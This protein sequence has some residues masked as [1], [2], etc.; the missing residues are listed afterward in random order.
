MPDYR[1]YEINKI[2]RVVGRPHH[3]TCDNDDDAVQKATP[4]MGDRDIE[5]WQGT[6]VVAQIRSAEGP[7]GRFRWRPDHREE[8]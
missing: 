6:R 1:I 2:G 5:V 7:P 4:L 3:I 8:G